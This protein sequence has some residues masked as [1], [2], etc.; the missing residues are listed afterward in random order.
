MWTNLYTAV[1]TMGKTTL[2]KQS[3]T[4]DNNHVLYMEEKWEI[5]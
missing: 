3:Y 4:K 2:F 5:L 1:K